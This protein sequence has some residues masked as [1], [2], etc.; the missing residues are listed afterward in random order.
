MIA[1]TN[2]TKKLNAAISG[3]G[4]HDSRALEDIFEKCRHDKRE[5]TILVRAFCEAYLV[6]SEN[7]PLKMRP[8]QET[9]VVTALTYPESGKQ[10]KMAIL[11][12]RGSGK[13]YALSIAATVYMFFKRFRDLVNDSGNERDEEA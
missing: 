2:E 8:L 6:D 5:M 12:P 13:S 3:A 11:A 9:I 1:V 4:A 10:R 7:R